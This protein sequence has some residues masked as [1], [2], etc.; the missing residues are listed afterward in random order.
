MA[1]ELIYAFRVMRLPLLDSK[2][3]A[4]GRIEDVVLLPPMPGEAPPVIGFVVASQRRRIFVGVGRITRLDNEGAHLRSSAIDLNPF[5]RRKG[6]VLLGNDLLDSKVGSETVSDVALRAVPGRASG[7]EVASVRLTG[8]GG[9]RRRRTARVVDWSE[10]APIF[11]TDSVAAE[12]AALRDLHPAEVA[13]KVRSLPLHHR[14][15][16]ANVMED[17]RLADLLEEL[18]ESEQLRIIEGLDL[19]R[20]TSVLEEMEYDDA[21]DLL[22]EMSGEQRTQVLENMDPEE[23]DVM[24]R[25]LAYGEATAGGLMIPDPIVLGPTTTVAEALAHIREPEHPSALAA[26]VYVTQPPWETPTGRYVGV[27]H[28]QRLLREAPSTELGH[29]LETEPVIDPSAT[30]MEV[31][32]TLAAYNLLSAAVCDEEKRILGVITVDDVLDRTLPKGWRQR[33]RSERKSRV[34]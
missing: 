15:Q 11:G 16:L 27:V 3:A 22:A 10:V 7:W 18:P 14:R 21:A 19:D 33:Q 24:R 32:E 5:K 9:L 8:V 20:L 34:T 30:D 29:I 25:L 2:D 12:A 6:E 26:Q 4:V 28:F 1:T 13:A 23:A 31:A 17:E